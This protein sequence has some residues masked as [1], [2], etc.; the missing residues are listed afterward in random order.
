MRLTQG[1][2]AIPRRATMAG[3]RKAA[4]W[5]VRRKNKQ[6]RAGSDEPKP[7]PI[8]RRAGFS[9]S[10]HPGSYA[11]QRKAALAAAG[12]DA[13]ASTAADEDDA[14]AAP[15]RRYG[16]W[17]AFCGKNYSGMQMCVLHGRVYTV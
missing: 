7:E 11:A 5:S 6:A 17:L 12:D 15:K 3:K 4:H 16:I 14:K 9:D 1:A 2:P 8:D 10:I 13:K